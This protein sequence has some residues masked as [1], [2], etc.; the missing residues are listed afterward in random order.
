MPAS[1]VLLAITLTALLA[2]ISGCSSLSEKEQ[3]F[4]RRYRYFFDERLSSVYLD[5]PARRRELEDHVRGIMKERVR[6]EFSDAVLSG[7]VKRGMTGTEV[8]FTMGPPR[9]KYSASAGGMTQEWWVYGERGEQ[10]TL[11]VENDLLIA[12]GPDGEG[13]MAVPE[14]DGGRE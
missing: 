13:P 5:D 8:L 7:E 14:L 6:E 2:L 1:R 9:K 12:V 10:I 4:L 3:E 11:V